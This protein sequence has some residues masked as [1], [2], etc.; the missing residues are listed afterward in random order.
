MSLDCAEIFLVV[1]SDVVRPSEA[2]KG[3]KEEEEEGEGDVVAFTR[4][5]RQV[6]AEEVVRDW[7]RNVGSWEE[8]ARREMEE[9]E[10]VGRRYREA[11]GGGDDESAGMSILGFL[12]CVFSLSVK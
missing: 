5:K 7:G 10:R 9:L 4:P 6:S 1:D 12:V 8:L 11:S 2:D 3:P